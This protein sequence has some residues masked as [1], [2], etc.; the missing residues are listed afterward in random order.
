LPR[1]SSLLSPPSVGFPTFA[2]LLSPVLG[3]LPSASF[4]PLK[5]HHPPGSPAAQ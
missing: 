3:C 2:S 5:R 4:I 1:F